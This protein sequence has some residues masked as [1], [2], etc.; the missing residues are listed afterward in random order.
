MD[1]LLYVLFFP[2]GQRLSEGEIQKL[3]ELEKKENEEMTT[4]YKA[5]LEKHGVSHPSV[6]SGPVGLVPSW[7]QCAPKSR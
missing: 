5:T 2:A 4:K 3:V 6:T 1:W 7:L